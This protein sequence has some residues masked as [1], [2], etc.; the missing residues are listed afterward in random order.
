MKKFGFAVL[1]GFGLLV[2]LSASVHAT[3]GAGQ[4]SAVCL[5][6]DLCSLLEHL[7]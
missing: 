3:S 4:H 7:M 5:V 1:T 2:V 6:C